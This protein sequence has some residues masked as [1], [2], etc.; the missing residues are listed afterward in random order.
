M[1]KFSPIEIEITKN[2]IFI[3]G[4]YPGRQKPLTKIVWQGN[5]SG[6]F[7]YDL[8]PNFSNVFITNITNYSID[9]YEV[10]QDMID[11]GMKELQADIDKHQPKKIICLGKFTSKHVRELKL[12]PNIV[13]VDMNHPAY[14]LRFNDAKMLESYKQRLLEAING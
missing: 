4:M 5:R 10:T 11:D 1:I 2:P 8:M 9:G 7:L 12:D 6:N 3:V 13:I 14:L